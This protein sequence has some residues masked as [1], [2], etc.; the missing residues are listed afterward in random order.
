M[1][2][3]RA[4]YGTCGDTLWQNVA[5]CRTFR[6]ALALMPPSAASHSDAQF[7]RAAALWEQGD[8][9]ACEDILRELAVREPAREDVIVLLARVMQSQGRLDAACTAMFQLCRAHDFPLELGLRAAQFIQQ[10]QRQPLAARLCDAI[11]ARRAASPALLALA[12][13]VAR[14]TGDF[15]KA[16]RFYLAAL[17]AGVDLDAWYVLGALAH[18]QRYENREHDDL[19]RFCAHFH[20]VAFSTRSRAATGFGLAKAYD[21]L[22]EQQNAA[23]ILREANALVRATVTWSASAW[24]EFVAARCSETPLRARLRT[25]DRFVPVFVLGLPRTGTTLTATRLAA[26]PRA[27]DRGELRF[28]RFIA[29][30][31]IGG[32][33]LA[34]PAALD[35]AAALYFAHARQD[36]APATWYIDQ[37]PLNFRFLHLIAALFPQARVI[38]CRRNRR[39]TALS[40]WSQDFAHADCAFAYDLPSIAAF[41]AGHDELMAHWQRTLPLPIYTL[42]YEALVADPTSTLQALRAFIGMPPSSET[43]TAILSINTASVWQARQPIYARS[44][45]R[46]RGYASYVP[47]LETLFPG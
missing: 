33:H 22:G 2:A 26:H 17:D 7:A 38:H 12:G 27:H 11:L 25:E 19:R 45:E 44:V 47:E 6:H 24:T 36:D 32:G 34:D 23:A 43:E 42:E 8:T 18:T 29:E 40:L 35:E 4:H 20:N 1:F 3:R 28:L 46:W 14:E 41:A 31:L 16:R 30:Q 21:D 15:D 10:C 37:D 13:N 39:D 9:A 5:S